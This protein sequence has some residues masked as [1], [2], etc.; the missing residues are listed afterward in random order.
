MRNEHYIQSNNDLDDV[1]F[2]ACTIKNWP[3]TSMNQQTKQKP[4]KYV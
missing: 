2:V 1:A 3:Q 4:F